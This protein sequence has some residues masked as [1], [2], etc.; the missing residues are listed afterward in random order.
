MACSGFN[1][2]YHNTGND[3][4]SGHRPPNSDPGFFPVSAGQ[5]ITASTIGGLRDAINAEITRWN[6]WVPGHTGITYQQYS[7]SIGQSLT[8]LANDLQNLS[9]DLFNGGSQIINW[10][11]SGGTSGPYTV[12][13]GSVVSDPGQTGVPAA[14]IIDDAQWNAIINSYNVVHN[15]CICNSD[16]ACNAVCACFNDCGC[17]YSDERL[18]CDIKLLETVDGLN[19]YEFSYLWNTA[20]RYVGVMAQELFG[21]KYEGAV[22]EGFRGYFQVDYNKLPVQMKEI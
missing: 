15:N 12:Y 4:C 2:S 19:I 17:N 8:I 6:Q 22:S 7:T 1:C 13:P 21:T 9:R 3:G 10:S 18:K 11:A 16:C 5:L 20:K 14:T